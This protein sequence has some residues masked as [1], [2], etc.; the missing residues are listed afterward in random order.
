MPTSRRGSRPTDRRATSAA[1]RWSSRPAS[2][3][4]SSPAAAIPSARTRAS[5][6]RRSRAPKSEI[7]E[8]C[9]NCGKP[10]VVKRGRFGQ[11]LAC[12]GYPECKTTRKI[13]ATKQ[14]VDGRQAGPDPRR[15]VP[16]VRVEPGHQAGPLRRVHGVQ[17]LSDLQVRQAEVDR[18]DAC[19]KDGGDIVERKSR[20]GKVF[21]GCANY[22]DCDFT[23]WNRPVAEKCPD[24]GAPFL[25]EKI[26]KKH[27]RQ[28]ICN[29]EE[30]ATCGPRN[31]RQRDDAALTDQGRSV[32][33]G[34][35]ARAARYHATVI[36]SSAAGWPAARRPGR[37]RRS[38]C[39]SSSTRC[40]RCARPPSTRPTARR[41]GL[42]QLLPR[43]QARQRRRPPQGGDAAA[44]LAGHAA[45]DASRV[46][47]GAAL[48]SIAS[49]SSRGHRAIA[50]HP[51][52]THRRREEIAGSRRRRRSGHRR[53]RSAD[54]GRAV[55][56]IAAL[57]GA[58]HLYFYDAI[59]PIVLAESIDMTKVFRASRWGE[60]C[61]GD[62]ADESA[63]N[64]DRPIRACGLRR[65]RRRGRL[66]E[67]PVHE[68]RVRARSTM[69]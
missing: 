2:S 56:D 14:G 66:P 45:A 43:R 1:S 11:F 64:P 48:A 58:E 23:L 36:T 8:T 49:G 30:C 51:L 39:R 44:R 60:A 41:A 25:V 50:R 37:R 13:I 15:E 42:Q 16:E 55:G 18:R 34:P 19:P 40:G 9:E 68:G 38:A 57:V 62:R 54:V 10:M 61:A 33:T 65:R 32:A 67:L 20:R 28:L 29:N 12:T 52:I 47:A 22:P 6:R 21:F 46:P 3:A 4:C 59:S 24:C 27:G 35:L 69:R 7:E 31:W 26:T 17:Q 5:S 53:H 63:A